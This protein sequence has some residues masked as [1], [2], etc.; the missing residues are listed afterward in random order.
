MYRK[1]I[2]A[3]DGSFHSE[4]AAQHA[5]AI[6]VSCG[7]EF[8]ALAVD[9]GEVGKDKLSSSVEHVCQYARDQGVNARGLV[10][11]GEAV[12]TI[13]DIVHAEHA[14]LLVTATRQSDYRLFVRS[15]P[16]QLMLRAPCSVL[17]IKPAGMSKKGTSMLLPVAHREISADERVALAS[18]LAKFYHYRI[19]ILHVIERRNWNDLPWDKLCTMRHHGEENMMSIANALKEK[20]ITSGVRAVI[21]QNCMNA[22]QKEV[23]VGKHDLVLLGASQRNILKQIISGNPIEQAVSSIFCDVVIWKPKQ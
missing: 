10:R 22:I 19:E 12:K 11:K 18:S 4:L 13:L 21:A 1:I 5:V 17:A 20:G 23:A 9:T 7:S 3:L 8:L 16:Q 15:V 6:A 14:D 2:S